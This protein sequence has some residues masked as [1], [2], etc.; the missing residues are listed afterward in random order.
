MIG[1]ASHPVGRFLRPHACDRAPFAAVV[2]RP[3]V[4][5]KGLVPCS[6]RNGPV[7]WPWQK[8]Q[9]PCERFANAVICSRIMAGHVTRPYAGQ[10][11]AWCAPVGTGPRR[12]CGGGGA[13]WREAGAGLSDAP[14]AEGVRCD[15]TGGG[16]NAAVAPLHAARRQ[17][18]WEEAA[19]TRKDVQ[20]GGAWSGPAGLAR[21]AGDEAVREADQAAVGASDF[22]DGRCEV[23]PGGVTVWMGLTR[24]LPGRC[25]DL[26][27]ELCKRPGV[28]HL[29]CDES[30]GDG[31]EGSDG[32]RAVGSCGHPS[33]PVV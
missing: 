31:C 15:A 9:G 7:S 5:L 4:S 14:L 23:L 27:L 10:D 32:D 17:D 11:Q 12:R 26:G 3:E 19:Q 16:H 33:V 13:R 21:G 18:R 22:A 2:C 8:P 25:P 29:R 20:A 30:A 6:G 24:H 28:A 1:R